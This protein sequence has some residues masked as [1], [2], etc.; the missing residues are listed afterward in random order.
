MR[1]LGAPRLPAASPEGTL[2]RHDG[3]GVRR[4]P[5]PV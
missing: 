2:P 4:Q 5:P 3:G 1:Q